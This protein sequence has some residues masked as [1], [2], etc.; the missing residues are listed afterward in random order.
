[1]FCPLIALFQA[2]DVCDRHEFDTCMRRF[3]SAVDLTARRH[4]RVIAKSQKQNKNCRSG[5]SV[6]STKPASASSKA[7]ASNSIG[8]GGALFLAVCRGKV[9]E[10]IDFADRHARAVMVVGIPY[11]SSKSLDVLLKKKHCQ[12]ASC[13]IHKHFQSTLWLRL[14]RILGPENSEITC[15]MRVFVCVLVTLRCTRRI[16]LHCRDTA[17]IHNK[18]S[19]L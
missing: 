15:S 3:R 1:M 12:Q 19:V 11:P 6:A 13:A 8:R 10:G 16:Q 17:G 7:Q 5:S 9:S 14:G 4:D 18:R 2:R